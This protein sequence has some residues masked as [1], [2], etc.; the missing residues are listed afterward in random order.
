MPVARLMSSDDAN[1]P[2][3]VWR[4]SPLNPSRCVS[5]L[6]IESRTDDGAKAATTTRAGNSETNALAA[7]ATL[8]STNSFSSNRSQIRQ[9]IVRSTHARM[10]S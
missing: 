5:V 9:K 4:P 6:R 8:R 3:T 7:S 10:E 2:L 1:A